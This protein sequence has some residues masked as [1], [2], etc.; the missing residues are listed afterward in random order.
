M[1]NERWFRR[2]L[3][4]RLRPDERIL[5]LGAGTGEMGAALSASGIEIDGLDLWPRPLAWPP[6]AEWH[7]ADLRSFDRYADYSA[8]MA[9]LILHHFTAAE[10][11]GLGARLSQ[12]RLIIAS[13]PARWRRSQTLCAALGPLFGV[14]HVTRHDA[15]VSIAAGFLRDELPRALGLTADRWQW[16]CGTSPIGAY[17]M[18]ALRR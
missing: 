8:V 10:L 6:T 16:I 17:R 11:L 1:G 14:N 5:E 3:R 4:R 18:I 13:E 15:D 12:A 9:N 2:E 7:R